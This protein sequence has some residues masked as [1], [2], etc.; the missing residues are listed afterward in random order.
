MSLIMSLK[1]N[2]HPVTTYPGGVS[3]IKEATPG[4]KVFILKQG[5]VSVTINDKKITTISKPGEVFGEIASIK[6]C[7]YGATITTNSECSFYVIDNLLTYLKKNPD[8]AIYLL[9]NLCDRIIAM[10]NTFKSAEPL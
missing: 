8:D 5:E 9:Q 4:G 10:N 6:G 1:L 2:D 3:I 7:K